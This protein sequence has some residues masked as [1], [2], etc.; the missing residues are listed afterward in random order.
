MN[1]VALLAK[2]GRKGVNS[3]LRA[4]VSILRKAQLGK[5]TV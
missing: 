4:V 3:E 5:K 2:V 1:L